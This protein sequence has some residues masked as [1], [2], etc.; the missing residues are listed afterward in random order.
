MNLAGVGQLLQGIGIAGILV[1]VLFMVGHG[2]YVTKGSHEAILAAHATLLAEQAREIA[3][4]E[5]EVERMHAALTALGR[6]DD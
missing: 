6:G 3:R 4:L 5:S 1:V 2:A